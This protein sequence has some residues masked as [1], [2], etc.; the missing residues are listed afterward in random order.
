[1]AASSMAPQ[2]LKTQSVFRVFRERWNCLFTGIQP[3][4]LGPRQSFA[5]ANPFGWP[6]SNCLGSLCPNSR[7]M[8]ATQ[9]ASLLK[10]DQFQS[11][12]NKQLRI[13]PDSDI[14]LKFNPLRVAK[15]FRTKRQSVMRFKTEDHDNKGFGQ[16]FARFYRP[17]KDNQNR[18]QSRLLFAVDAGRGHERINHEENNVDQRI[19]IRRESDCDR[20]EQS[21]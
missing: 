15:L 14:Q 2:I 17:T 20:R 10:S 1:M 8:D 4:Y 16:I 6:S 11:G 18:T 3:V 12:L 13:H 21:T 5:A 7:F 19:A 9:Q